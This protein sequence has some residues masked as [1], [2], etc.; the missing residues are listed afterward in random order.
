MTSLM[1][2][3][4]N[5]LYTESSPLPSQ[6]WNQH[7]TLTY[8]IPPP[9]EDTEAEMSIY[10]R[11]TQV[12]EY[13]SI[14]ARVWLESGGSVVGTYTLQIPTAKDSV[15]QG[16]DS[17]ERL[18]PTAAQTP[19][20]SDFISSKQPIRLKAGHEYTLKVAHIMRKYQIDNISHVGITV[21]KASPNGKP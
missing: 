21:E 8:T 4:D 14:S 5:L 17:S 16:K 6:Q 12:F 2:C 13:R 9:P 20:Y 1:S 15:T 7:D 3:Q 19:L 11:V 18:L 10:A